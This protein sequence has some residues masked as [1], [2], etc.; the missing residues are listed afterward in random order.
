MENEKFLA[1]QLTPDNAALLLI[2]HQVGTMT[3]GIVDLDP[4][5]LKNNTLWLAEAAN[6]FNLPTLLTTS[7]PD[8]ANGPLFTELV[9]TLPNA[10]VIDRLHI[11]AW[12]DP[13]FV[14]AVEA[15]GRKKLIMAGVT[16][17]V[18]L[19]FPAVSAAQAGY[20]VYAVMDASGTVTMQAMYAAMFRMSQ[21]GVKIANTNMVVAELESYWGNETAA[22][23]GALY[24]KR[25][26][27]FGYIYSHLQ[28]IL[29][30]K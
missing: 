12:N 28:Y 1:E 6:I 23:V 4:V 11:N 16:A 24:A 21:A 17:D 18:C 3:F 5:T 14:K 9:N 13:V 30:K 19:T 26:P 25:L 29:N 7:N 8:G 27:H 20:D 15:T 10:P 22:Q 2:D